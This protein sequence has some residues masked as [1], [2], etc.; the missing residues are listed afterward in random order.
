[1][2]DPFMPPPGGVRR[3]VLIR[4]L[5]FRGVRVEGPAVMK[6][7]SNDDEAVV[8][9]LTDPVPHEVVRAISDRFLVRLKH[10]YTDED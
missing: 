3:D 8:Q 1:M 6:L 4:R 9:H 2:Y 10:L 7:M 5:I